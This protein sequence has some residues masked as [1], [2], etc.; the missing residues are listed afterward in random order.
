MR[1]VTAAFVAFGSNRMASTSPMFTPAIDTGAPGL[2]SPMLSNFA[3][4]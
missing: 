3:S 4:T 2:R 1:N